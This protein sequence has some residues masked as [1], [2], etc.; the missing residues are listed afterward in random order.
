MCGQ[1]NTSQQVFSLMGQR[2]VQLWR[3]W[4]TVHWVGTWEGIM[5]CM[6]WIRQTDM[7]EA[8]SKRRQWSGSWQI[9]W[10]TSQTSIFLFTVQSFSQKHLSVVETDWTA[11]KLLSGHFLIYSSCRINCDLIDI[12]FI[13]DT[14]VNKDYVRQGKMLVI[15]HYDDLCRLLLKQNLSLTTQHS[16]SLKVKH[17]SHR[18]ILS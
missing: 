2:M 16:V 12:L 13:C 15:A 5:T 17:T 9:Q 7:W 1:S 14:L 10:L 6:N 18:I 3:G 11:P 8:K 4:P